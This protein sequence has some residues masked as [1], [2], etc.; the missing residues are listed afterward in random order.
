MVSQKLVWELKFPALAVVVFGLKWSGKINILLAY[1]LLLQQFKR[2]ICKT[3]QLLL[4]LVWK[5]PPNH[6]LVLFGGKS[7]IIFVG[8]TKV[9]PV[10]DNR[11]H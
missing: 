6:F 7:R 5:E 2:D 3:G 8:I 11:I 4:R 9:S 10:G 1:V